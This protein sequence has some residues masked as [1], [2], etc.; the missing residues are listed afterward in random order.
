MADGPF[1]ML[2]TTSS[3][4]NNPPGSARMDSES[5]MVSGYNFCCRSLVLYSFFPECT[6]SFGALLGCVMPSGDSENSFVRDLEH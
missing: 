2:E 3:T 1:A 6:A 4:L 5:N